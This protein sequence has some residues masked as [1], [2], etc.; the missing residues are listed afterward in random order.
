LKTNEHIALEELTRTVIALLLEEPYLG[1]FAM[2]ILKSASEN[3]QSIAIDVEEQL[4]KLVIAPSFW[5]EEEQHALYR[6]GLLKHELLHLALRHPLEAH[7]YVHRKLYDIAADLCV[8]QYIPAHYLSVDYITLS[9]LKGFRLKTFET[10]DYYYHALLKQLR[11]PGS[12]KAQQYLSDLLAAEG[13]EDLDRHRFWHTSYALLTSADRKNLVQSIE[14]LLIGAAKRHTPM[15]GEMP[16]PAALKAYLPG[17]AYL[18]KAT[19]DWKRALRLFVA[20][21][22]RTYLKSTI[23]RPSSRYG[24]V[25]GIKIKRRQKLM[26]ALDTSGSIML[27]LLERFFQ[28]VYHIWRTGAE[29]LIVEFDLS[30]QRQYF[31]RGKMPVFIKGR[32]GTD[33]DPPLQY[34]NEEY[35]PDAL[36]FFTDGRAPKPRTNTPF[37]IMW[38]ISEDGIEEG[39]DRWGTLPGRKVKMI[40]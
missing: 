17:S 1:H 29:V 25:P 20:S 30:V 2:G 23:K 28:E 18:Q 22:E 35:I 6:Y 24:T 34:A 27:E 16:L 32:G 37:P 38:L 21:S 5:M 4:P 14:Q 9:H 11:V 31:Y 12:G 39:G 10:A 19:I 15:D 7:H 40:S 36:I 26:I 8:N 33:F 3:I 13:R